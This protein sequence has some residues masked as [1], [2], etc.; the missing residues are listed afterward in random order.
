MKLKLSILPVL[1]LLTACAS[2]GL[3]TP[4]S[5]DERLSVAYEQ[6]T[7]A[8][9]SIATA[10]NLKDLNGKDGQA[11]LAIADNARLLLDSAKLATASGDVNSAEGRLL[12]A[13][14]VLR[15]LST[16]LRS[17]GVK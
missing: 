8:L 11:V 13:T 3:V 6:H 2:M 7:A 16:F 15:E 10:V 14:N 12:L 1:I 17:R 5:F 4:Q 9:Q